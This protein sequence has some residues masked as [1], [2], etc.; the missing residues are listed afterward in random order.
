M[1]KAESSTQLTIEDIRNH[2]SEEDKLLLLTNNKAPKFI[3]GLKSCQ[4]TVNEEFKFT[5]QGRLSKHSRSKPTVNLIPMRKSTCLYIL[6][7]FPKIVDR[8]SI[9][10]DD[11]VNL[12][13]RASVYGSVDVDR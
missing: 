6:K 9:D 2:L 5:V 1:G 13:C 10:I 12:C 7:V 11:E 8:P 3:E 4:A